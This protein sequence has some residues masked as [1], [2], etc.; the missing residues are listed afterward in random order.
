MRDSQHGGQNGRGSEGLSPLARTVVA[1]LLAEAP[2]ALRRADPVAVE[3]VYS[4]VLSSDGF[5]L[6]DLR[7]EARRARV[8]EADLI[9]LVCPDVARRLGCDWV[10]DRLG[11]AQVSVGMGRLQMLVRQIGG[12]LATT[13]AFDGASFLIVLPEGEQHSFGVQLL[14]SQLRR[15][16][17]S[18]HLQ[19]G[20]SPAD[21]RRMVQE[22]HYDCALVS[23]A[24]EELLESCA[25]VVKSLKDGSS[26]RLCVA[27]GGAALEWLTGLHLLVGA[28]IST[29][30]AMQALAMARQIE[31]GRSS[32]KRVTSAEDVPEN[33]MEES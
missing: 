4:A 16:G 17:A 5:S 9:D 27:V 13:I 26:G 18:V 25:K 7:L 8:T 1:R 22:R 6:P 19:I 12:E 20:T 29:N 32:W 24:N 21:L 30:D 31:S 14:A 23:I 28:D 10:E 15:G 11:F 3:L 2:R 33:R